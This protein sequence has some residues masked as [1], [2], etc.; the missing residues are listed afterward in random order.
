MTDL[1]F[2]ISTGLKNIIGKEL[3]NNDDI[4]IFELVK[5]SYDAKANHVKIIFQDI[6]GPTSKAKIFIVDDGNGMSFDDI[7][8]KW[9]VVGFSEKKF[10]VTKE[11]ISK[12]GIISK[13]RAFAGAKGIGRFSA[14]RL[15]RFMSMYTRQ[16]KTQELNK[17]ELDWKDFEQ[18]QEENF[19]SI[20]VNHSMVSHAPTSVLKYGDFSKG[21]IIEI[22]NLNSK[23]DEVKLLSLKHY[24]Q[25]L[26]NPSIERNIHDF[27]I[28]II[29]PDFFKIDAKRETVDK[30]NGFIKNIVFEKFEKLTTRVSCKIVDGKIFTQVVD[31]GSLIFDL[32]EDNLFSKLDDVYTH[33]FY[34]TPTARTSFTKIMGMTHREYGSIFFY[35]NGFRIH[36][37][38][39]EEDDWLEL[40]KRKGQ[41]YARTL[42]N[43]EIIGRVEVYG[44]QKGFKETSSRDGGVIKSESLIQ[45]KKFIVKKALERLEKYVV[46]GIHWDPED[47]KKRK[48]PE[49]ITNDS[50]KVISGL[51]GKTGTSNLKVTIGKDL[52]Q[53]IKERQIK[54]I[55]EI[56]RNLEI[57]KKSVK[58]KKEKEYIENQLKSLRI[59][60]R[61]ISKAY[62]KTKKELEIKTKETYFLRKASS[63][64]KEIIMNLNHS[65]KLCTKKIDGYI[66]R[67]GNIIKKGGSVELIIPWLDKISLEN[68]KVK[69]HAKIVSVAN[70]NLKS[71]KREDELVEYIK[72]YVLTMIRGINGMNLEF[73]NE[74]IE[75]HTKFI[76]LEISTMLD[77]LIDNSIKALANKI[78]IRFEKRKEKICMYFGDNGKGIKKNDEQYLFTRGYTTT[79]GSG[80]GIYHVKS[81]A[82]EHGGSAMFVGNGFKGLGKG[83]VFEVI[84]HETD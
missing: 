22:S 64:D 2:R 13:N 12:K 50:L 5:N 38:G 82:E 60:N 37:Y 77:N 30:V 28:E 68:K 75:Y 3:I 76:P 34:L 15:G 24:L 10:Q 83:A 70:F 40:E 36:P 62:K 7:K 56:I 66:L 17:I 78:S 27:K 33:I 18:D 54:S 45:L 57:L 47:E 25:R 21:T 79:S 42:S 59:V 26:I 72:E 8:K 35:K 29:S 51:L 1:K 4:A 61:N 65:I 39:G 41:G 48:T 14:D 19:D 74:N 69:T 81:I 55:P 52:F 49:Q 9:L 80:L 31:K 73:Y 11:I 71:A 67:I 53:K 43:R 23:W 63:G 6:M 44:E 46:E 16:Q 84:L 32:E 58:T 20:N